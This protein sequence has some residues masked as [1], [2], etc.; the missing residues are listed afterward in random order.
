MQQMAD[1]DVLA[2][3]MEARAILHGHFQL[4]S[5]RHSDTYV[6]CARV[7]EDPALTT[8]L[9]EAIVAGLPADAG[10]DRSPAETNSC[11]NA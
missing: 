11:W 10:A 3:L 8:R 5:G 7:L 1:T 4:T 9:A 6:Q 2:A